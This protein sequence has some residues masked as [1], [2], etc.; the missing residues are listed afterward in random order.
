[1]WQVLIT[2]KI[3]PP[4]VELV[5]EVAEVDLWE[6]D[7][8]IPREILLQKIRD[9]DGLLCLLTDRVDKEILEAGEKLRVVSNYAVG[10]DN[11]DVEE[12]KRRNIIVTN[13]PGVLTET[14]AD[15]AW[16]LLLCT[17]RRIAEADRFTKAGKFT[18]WSPTMLLGQD[19][20][21]K[22]LGLIGLGR[23]GFAVAKR[24]KGFAMRILYYDVAR[25]E[26]KEQEVGAEFVPLKI[27]LTESD[28]I[29]IHTPLT[30]KTRHLIGEKE[31]K[32]MKRTAVLV[33]T[34]RGPVIVEEALV[35]ALKEG[36]IFGAGLDVYEFEPKL[37]A[38]LTD[39]PNVVLAPHIGSASVET[40]S[41]MAEIA[42]KNL[43]LALQGKEPLHRVV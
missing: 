32:M 15:L 5:R 10:F 27:L 41:K 4:G 29:S 17:A 39:L 31:L 38:G 9:K 19:V 30:P 13:T 16:A 2:R 12:A 3:P 22:T 36:W 23:I 20:Y 21:G 35:K 8:V 40:R 6:E 43:I 18:G 7:R 1:M 42:A 25:M 11:L 24:A 28:F 14:T 26:S 37:T 33:N 34:A